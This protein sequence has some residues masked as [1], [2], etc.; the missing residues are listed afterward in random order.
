ML[1][2]RPPFVAEQIAATLVSILNDPIPNLDQF[3]ADV[4]AKLTILI[5]SMLIKE[6]ENRVTSVRQVAAELEVI[7]NSL[8]A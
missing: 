6:R 8:S 3:R 4:P 5:Q 2:G 7:R 1:A